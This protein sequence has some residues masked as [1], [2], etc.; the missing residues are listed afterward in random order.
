MTSNNQQIKEYLPKHQQKLSQNVAKNTFSKK[1]HNCKIYL[2]RTKVK[3]NASA[4]LV[5]TRNK[6]HSTTGPAPV[7]TLHRNCKQF[8]CY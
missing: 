3:D 1:S 8:A 6:K 5:I 4:Q 2:K 7:N